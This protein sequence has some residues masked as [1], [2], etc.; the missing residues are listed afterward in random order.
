MVELAFSLNPSSTTLVSLQSSYYLTLI[1]I[2]L[3]LELLTGSNIT[4]DHILSYKQ[5]R[6]DTV[7]GWSLFLANLVN[8]GLAYVDDLPSILC[9]ITIWKTEFLI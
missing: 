6:T 8:A 2:A 7:L 9:V 4:L 5:I 1:V 3:F